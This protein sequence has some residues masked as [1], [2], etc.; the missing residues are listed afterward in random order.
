MNSR[1]SYPIS[2]FQDRH[3]RPLRHPSDLIYQTVTRLCFFAA[4]TAGEIRPSTA[5]AF[6]GRSTAT[7]ATYRWDG[8]GP[9]FRKVGR[10]IVYAMGDLEAWRAA[11]GPPR[12]P[13]PSPGGPN[14][15]QFSDLRRA[16]SR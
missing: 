6:L 4:W 8:T 16:A 3:V 9:T 2:G 7:L 14:V 11:H 13:T 10:R 5:A 12:T 15:V 1:M